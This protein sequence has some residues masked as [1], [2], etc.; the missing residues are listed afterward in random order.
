VNVRR[1]IALAAAASLAVLALA[2]CSNQAGVASQVGTQ[3]ITDRQVADDVAELQ[4]QLARIP[5][6]KFDEQTATATVVSTLTQNLVLQQAANDQGITV[7]QGDVDRYLA[8]LETTNKTTFQALVDNAAS[9]SNIPASQISDVVRANI[10]VSG[11]VA[12]LA[13]GVTDQAKQ[14]TVFFDYLNKFSDQ[15]GV[16]VSPRFGTWKNFALGPVPNDLSVVPTPSTSPSTGASAP[17]G[18]PSDPA[19]PAPTAS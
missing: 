17:A 14:K 6:A 11:L 8:N 2:G 1:P 13:P 12:K 16:E 3:S 19:S 9:G 4:A 15:I 5:S 10:I 7:S 18:S